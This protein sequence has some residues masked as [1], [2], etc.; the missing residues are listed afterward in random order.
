MTSSTEIT[1]NATVRQETGKNV[2]RRLRAAGQVPATIYGGG[3][4]PA[5]SS[6]ARRE[7]AALI[8]HHGRSRI[9]HLNLDGKSVP[10]KIAKLQLDP[11]RDTVIHAD[12]IRVLMTEQTTFR[13]PLRVVGEPH[14]VKNADGVLD[15]V[16]HDLEI[17]CLP[18]NLPE[19][20]TVS[21]ESLG[22]GE[23]LSVRDLAKA[24]GIEVLTDGDA[25]IATVVSPAGA[26]S[27][28]AETPAEPEVI[29]KGKVE[30]Q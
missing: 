7:L 29:R 2:S 14:G 12:F 30:E 5:T 22:V 3:E 26:E 8:R 16:L 28:S 1:L 15:V 19:A 20:I 24:E 13:V 25:V 17:R 10:V 18:G 9:I 27:S 11:V 21:V 6:V 23:H 4:D